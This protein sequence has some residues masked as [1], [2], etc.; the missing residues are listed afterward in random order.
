MNAGVPEGWGDLL[1]CPMC[2]SAFAEAWRCGGCGELYVE[3][4]GAPSLLPAALASRVG[5]D[6]HRRW[7]EAL[8]GLDAWRAR[9]RGA[10]ATVASVDPRVAALVSALRPAGTVLDVGGGDGAKRAY[11]PAGVTR[12]L[13]VDPGA[14][15]AGGP[16]E[17]RGVAWWAVQGVGE[18][19]PVQSESVDAVLSLSAMDYFM[20]VEGGVAEWA[21]AL[22]PAGRLGLFVTAHPPAVARA[23]ESPARVARG[24]RALG[25]A[26]LA[27]VGP[28]GAFALAIDGLRATA[29]EH[30]RYLDEGALLAAVEARFRVD[31]V[32]RERGRYSTTLRVVAERRL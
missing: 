15:G 17:E 4:D 21:R 1:A 19:L 7:R 23:R 28:R 29:R 24:V 31:E 6:V 18:F 16:L 13:A 20:D 26:V 12:Y 9:R 8:R 3:R 30:T 14:R 22:R 2:K 32:T 10:P 27:E 5:D 11:L 25:P